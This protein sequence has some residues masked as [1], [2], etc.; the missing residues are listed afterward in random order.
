MRLVPYR[1]QMYSTFMRQ[2]HLR[3]IKTFIATIA[4]MLAIFFITTS[5]VSCTQKK[6]PPKANARQRIVSLSPAAT[7]IL[8]S[9]SLQDQL[10]GIDRWSAQR[11]DV[12]PNIP[13]FDMIHPDAERI[14]ALEPTIIFVSSMT[15]DATGRDPFAPFSSSGVAVIYIPVSETL[16]AICDDV[17]MIARVTGTVTAGQKI[18][19]T[20]NSEINRIKEI[21]QTIPKA[22]RRTVVMEIEPA[23]AIYSFGRGV[24]LNELLETA[25]SI[26]IFANESGWLAVNAEQVFAHNPDV[27]LTN[28]PSDDPVQEILSR[29]GWGTLDAVRNKRVFV[30]DNT[31]SSQPA[32]A[33]TYALKEIAEAVYPE[34]FCK[35]EL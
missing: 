11:R 6:T 2:I 4:S 24:Y 31:S 33:V 19:D 20:M 1:T 22:K 32:P 25:G 9:L 16:A 26:N 15:R 27:I 12:S 10:V 23:P 21:V 17:T 8:A 28:T 14:M 35:D 30:I 3:C 13:S 5:L 34:W 18:I 7:A 29:P